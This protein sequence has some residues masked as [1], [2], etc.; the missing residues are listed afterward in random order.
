MWTRRCRSAAIVLCWTILLLGCAS[1]SANAACVNGD[2][3]RISVPYRSLSDLKITC[4]E[5]VAEDYGLPAFFF[6]LQW[7]RHAAPASTSS[8]V[9]GVGRHVSS[10]SFPT[11]NSGG[12]PCFNYDA[13]LRTATLKLKRLRVLKKIADVEGV[14]TCYKKLTGHPSFLY[15]VARV[16]VRVTD[17]PLEPPVVFVNATSDVQTSVVGGEPLVF[18]CSFSSSDTSLL[19]SHY[20]ANVNVLW[21]IIDG[22]S[23]IGSG[24][25]G[26]AADAHVP[27]NRSTND[28]WPWQ[29]Q[30]ATTTTLYVPSG[31]SRGG[32]FAC[33]A[34]SPIYEREKILREVAVEPVS[35]KAERRRRR[36]VRSLPRADGDAAKIATLCG[37]FIG[38]LI[39]SAAFVVLRR[40][41]MT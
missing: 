6:E 38:V 24:G 28:D 11:S 3:N 36:S 25:G 34:Q 9:H 31:F 35:N 1:W 4:C 19:F 37:V 22:G 15:V 10:C 8:V 41:Q 29:I 7:R 23:G 14:Y 17:I 20:E 18:P 39:V 12:N 5:S 30:D 13:S 33:V 16:E 26:G 21:R 32:R 40:R 27:T 2:A